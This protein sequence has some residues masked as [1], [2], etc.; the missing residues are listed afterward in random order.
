MRFSVR[1]VGFFRG[2]VWTWI[3][4]IGFNLFGVGCEFVFDLVFGYC[5][6]VPFI[7][8]CFDVYCGFS[9]FGLMFV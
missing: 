9:W 2:Q 1:G 5:L 6:I 8:Y 3:T 4:A 7:G